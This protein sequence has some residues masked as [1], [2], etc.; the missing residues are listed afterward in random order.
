MST[1]LELPLRDVHLPPPP[2][3]WPPAPGWWWLGAGLVL[4]LLVLLAWWLW[5]RRRRQRWS[6]WFLAQCGQDAD[7]QAV[8]AISAALRRA[9]RRSRPGAELLDGEAW[10]RFLD[11]PSG[12][13][14][15]AGPGRL[16]LD[17][18]FRPALEPAQVQALRELAHGRFLQLMEG[19]RR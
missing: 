5:R 11:G 17:G 9:A 14:F 8:A 19:R 15:S 3:L 4:L 12:Q 18:A 7:A 13:A 2:P 1:H 10:L 16:L 6:Q